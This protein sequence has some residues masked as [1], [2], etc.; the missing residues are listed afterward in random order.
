MSDDAPAVTRGWDFAEGANRTA[1]VLVVTPEEAGVIRDVLARVS[2][3]GSRAEI[4]RHLFEALEGALGYECLDD[5]GF[6]GEIGAP[7][8]SEVFG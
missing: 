7:D 8:D 5:D 2:G 6:E 4:A 1:F 3:A